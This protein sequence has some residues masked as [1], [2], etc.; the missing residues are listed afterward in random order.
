MGMAFEIGGVTP[1]NS[2]VILI[3]TRDTKCFVFGWNNVDPESRCA[4]CFTREAVPPSSDKASSGISHAGHPG[5][6]ALD[7]TD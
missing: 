5:I 2:I 4:A 1:L 6:V 3:V 7:H